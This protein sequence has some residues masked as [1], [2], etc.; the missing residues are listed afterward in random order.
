MPNIQSFDRSMIEEYLRRKGFPFFQD[1]EGDYV[2]QFA[3]NE[4]WGCTVAALLGI[5]GPNDNIYSIR[6][7]SDRRIP[8]ADWQKVIVLCNRWNDETLWPKAVLSLRNTSEMNTGISLEAYLILDMGI[9]QE[10][11][12]DYTDKIMGAGLSFWEWLHKDQGY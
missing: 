5:K 2:L 12:E 9:H 6:L 7:I 1:D 3:H 8:L 11:F 4:D 10:L